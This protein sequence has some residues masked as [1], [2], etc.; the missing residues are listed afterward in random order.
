MAYTIRNIVESD[1]ELFE[2]L[3]TLYGALNDKRDVKMAFENDGHVNGYA[4]IKIISQMNEFKL[5][6][7]FLDF[8]TFD[9]STKE[10]FI[11]FLDHQIKDNYVLKIITN[12]DEQEFDKINFLKEIGFIDDQNAK[13]VEG[14]I[15]LKITKPIFL[16]RN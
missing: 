9:E 6:N 1:L 2:D 3:N 16:E 12:I 5:G 15:P 8:K 13:K 10:A 4:L 14:F 7:I 11:E